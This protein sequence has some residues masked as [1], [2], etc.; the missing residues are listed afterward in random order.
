M[1]AASVIR[2]ARRSRSLGQRELGEL[3][4]ISQPRLSLIESGKSTPG[5]DTVERLLRSSGHRLVSVP[6]VREDAAT[7]AEGIAD[8]LEHSDDDRALRLYIQLNDNLAAEHGAIRF[9]LCIAEPTTTGQKRWDAAIA[10]LVA[11]RLNEEALPRPSWVDDPNR[12]LARTWTLGAGPYT[13]TPPPR[14]VPVEFL[15][16]RVLIDRDTLVSA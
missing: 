10:A 9:A 11:L 13:I 3:A 5:F 4:Q 7:L 14:R 15:D 1:T 16:R 8:A 2:T 12:V 6:T